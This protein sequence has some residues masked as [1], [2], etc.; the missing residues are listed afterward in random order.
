MENTHTHTQTHACTY[1]QKPIS[2]TLLIHIYAEIQIEI[3]TDG[4][5]ERI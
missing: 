5:R 1:P 4:E 2:K 3:E